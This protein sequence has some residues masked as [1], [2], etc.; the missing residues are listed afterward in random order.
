MKNNILAIVWAVMAIISFVSSF[1][2]PLYFKIIGLAFGAI[3]MFV[4]IAWF[5]AIF[6]FRYKNKKI[7]K[8][9]LQL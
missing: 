9:E 4:I 7:G 2:A 6:V 5:V 3:N 8:D 1:W